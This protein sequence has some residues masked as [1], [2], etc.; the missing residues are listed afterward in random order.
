MNIRE[1]IKKVDIKNLIKVFTL[2]WF[3]VLL[4]FM[5]FANIGLNDHF[6]VISWLGNV[7]I[8][9]GIMVFGLLMGES[10][11]RDKQTAK[12][13]GLYQTTL[14]AFT[15]YLNSLED[16]IIYFSQFFQ[17]FM[18]RELFDKKVNY[19][20][21][22]GVDEKKAKNIIKYCTMEDVDNLQNHPI[23]KED[24]NGNKIIIR[25]VDN[26]QALAIKDVLSGAITLDASNSYYYLSAFG[27]PN[28]KSILEVG[29]QLD[30]EIKFNKTSNRVS[31]LV[32]AVIV[33]LVFCLFTFKDFGGEDGTQTTQ[34]WMNLIFRITSLLTSLLSGWLS[35]VIDVKLQAEKID[36]KV[37]ILRMFKT[38]LDKGLFIPKSEDELAKEEYENYLKEEEEK[39]KNIIDPE[40]IDSEEEIYKQKEEKNAILEIETKETKKGDGLDG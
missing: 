23:E 14:R 13:D 4:V 30:K 3:V 12:V 7:L 34:A 2:L 25:Q 8:V 37:K 24:E 5:T 27:K 36:N 35:S 18:P 40:I 29:K 6:D 17:W 11:G 10:I 22:N 32:T 38:S 15:D 1:K 21:M 31:K 26:E 16:V 20:I 39:R 33:S 9:L 28:S 19:L